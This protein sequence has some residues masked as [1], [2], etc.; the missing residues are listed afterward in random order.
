MVFQASFMHIVQAKLGQADAGDNEAK[1]IT[2]LAPE[3]V[4]TSDPV[5][6]SPA[7]YRTLYMQTYCKY[8]NLSHLKLHIKQ[9]GGQR[10]FTSTGK[11][12]DS[13][14]LNVVSGYHIGGLKNKICPNTVHN[15]ISHYVSTKSSSDLIIVLRSGFLSVLQA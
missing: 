7:R 10:G 14:V 6:R 11:S 1:L 4:R 3:W 9:T 8:F 15:S 13:G 2:K 12:N 5:I